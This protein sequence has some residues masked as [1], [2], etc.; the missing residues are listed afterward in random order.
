[1]KQSGVM[2]MLLASGAFLMGSTVSADPDWRNDR[3]DRDGRYERNY[4]DRDRDHRHWDRGRDYH[5]RD[6]DYYRPRTNVDIRISAPPVYLGYSTRHP[7]YTRYPSA[8]WMWDHGYR[9]Y[10]YRNRTLVIYPDR[11]WERAPAEKV[12]WMDSN[13]QPV[14]TQQ[15]AQQNEE[16][17]CREYSA[18]A[19]VN[20]RVQQVYGTACMQ[21]D[22]T[23]QI[24]E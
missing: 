4:R 3:N 11:S 14:V 10:Y 15:T 1:M 6:R 20:G 17:Y 22:G 9:P 13:R 24:V 23:W 2:A 8:Y 12:Y 18:D 21:P 16:R 5:R 7:R 19:D